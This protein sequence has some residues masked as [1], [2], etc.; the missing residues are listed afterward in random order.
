[1]SA[2]T[3][4]KY[5]VIGVGLYALYKWLAPNCKPGC[6]PLSTALCNISTGIANTLIS[7]GILGCNISLNGNVQFPNGTQAALNSL[8][9]G[10]DASGNV[11]VQYSGGVYQINSG[12]SNSCGNW[13]A[14]QVS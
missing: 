11:Y 10:S 7:W 14:T 4:I 2:G 1:V 5:G 6:N 3:V 9:V 8:P 12:G 13:T